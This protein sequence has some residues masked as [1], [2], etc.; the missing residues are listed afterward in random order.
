MSK[1]I[2]SIHSIRIIQTIHHIVLYVFSSR[3]SIICY[4]QSMKQRAATPATK[5]TAPERPLAEAAPVY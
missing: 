2:H 3:T 1:D 5:A 4:I